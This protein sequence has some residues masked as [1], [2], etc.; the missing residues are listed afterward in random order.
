[1]FSYIILREIVHSER[2]FHNLNSLIAP[3][4]FQL[5]HLRFYKR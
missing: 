5:P 2:G 3:A 1:M 4:E